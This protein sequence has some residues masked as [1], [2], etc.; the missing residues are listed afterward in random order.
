MGANSSPYPV[1]PYG[2]SPMYPQTSMHMTVGA[3]EALGAASSGISD[4][5]PRMM[6]VC[7]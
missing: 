1:K 3:G 4:T 5:V 2:C 7:G 6:T